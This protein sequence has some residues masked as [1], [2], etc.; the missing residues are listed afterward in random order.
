M[1]LIKVDFS[2]LVNMICGSNLLEQ[3]ENII[4]GIRLMTLYFC[5]IGNLWKSTK[6]NC[7][8]KKTFLI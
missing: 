1:L 6:T 4:V 7:E 3:L 5:Q 8:F 2:K